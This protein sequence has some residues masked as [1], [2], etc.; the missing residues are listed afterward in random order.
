VIGRRAE[1]SLAAGDA[2][3]AADAALQAIREFSNSMAVVRHLFL[4]RWCFRADASSLRET[5]SGEVEFAER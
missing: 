3:A 1:L 5:D 2:I 4:R